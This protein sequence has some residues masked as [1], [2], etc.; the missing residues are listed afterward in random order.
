MTDVVYFDKYDESGAYHW[1]E[2]DRRYANW[3]RYNPALDGRYQVTR[4]AVAALGR[5][6]RLLDVGCGDG[7]LMARLSPLFASVSGVDADARAIQFAREKLQ[8]LANCDVRHV[9]GDELP[10]DARTFDIVTSADVIEHL[11][12]A[13]RHL[14]G[15]A[16]VLKPDGALVVTTPQWRAD[17]VWDTRHEKEYRAEEL[18]ELLAA[19]F[20]EVEM[21]YYW[22]AFWSRAY[23][24]RLGWRLLKLLA[25]QI[26]NPFLTVGER[27]PERY[28]QLIA[29]CRR[30]RHTDTAVATC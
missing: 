1:V 16:R 28:G 4:Q 11:T 22:P 23:E 15:I 27:H 2:C 20:S 29:V 13:A 8:A 14:R 19:H 21:R 5:G 17:G 25:I 12:D 30:A 10:F 6:G 18:R 9:A 26:Y 3:K 24:T 7:V